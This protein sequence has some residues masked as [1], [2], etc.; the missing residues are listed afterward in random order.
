MSPADILTDCE[1]A[2]LSLRVVGGKLIVAPKDRIT[3]ELR[4]RIVASR[5]ALIVEATLA[6]RA[7]VAA[8]VAA[9]RQAGVT[10][11]VEDG[12]ARAEPYTAVNPAW[13]ATYQA[14]LLVA[15]RDESAAAFL[16]AGGCEGLPRDR[17]VE[18]LEAPAELVLSAG[19]PWGAYLVFA[20]GMGDEMRAQAEA[21]E[22]RAAKSK[23]LPDTGN[24]GG[25]PRTGKAKKRKVVSGPGLFHGGD[26][27]DGQQ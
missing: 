17:G 18:F 12:R 15:L 10:F 27:H 1:D 24:A 16:A 23:H 22:Q 2:G 11:V 6:T 19:W 8:I 26:R 13:L 25:T 7:W 14:D 20:D 5:D 9:H 21:A 3:D 4:Q